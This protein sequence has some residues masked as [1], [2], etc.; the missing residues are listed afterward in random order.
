MYICQKLDIMKHSVS[1]S[2][3]SDQDYPI[4]TLTE[5]IKVSE[6]KSK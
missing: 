6:K 5:T 2:L 3:N 4:T 1:I